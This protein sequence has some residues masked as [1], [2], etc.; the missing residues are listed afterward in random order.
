MNTEAIEMTSLITIHRVEG[1]ELH[2]QYAG[3]Y[4]PQP[5]YVEL[6]TETGD[7]RASY[8][9]NIGRG[10][11]VRVFNGIVRRWRIAALKADAANA[12]LEEIA[13]LAERVYYDSKTVWDGHNFVGRMGEDAQAAVEEIAVLIERHEPWDEHDR[14]SIWDAYNWFGSIGGEE[15][16][17]HALGITAATTDEELAAI[18]EREEVTANIEGVDVLEGAAEHLTRLRDHARDYVTDETGE[19]LARVVEAA[20]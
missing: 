5:C 18:I 3:E 1:L 15:A 12:L 17:R 9:A 14:V 7:L 10:V 19:D 4:S 16:Q 13:P 8:D 6:D 20:T 11:P 2:F